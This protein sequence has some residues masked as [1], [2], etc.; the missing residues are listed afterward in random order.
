MVLATQ[1]PLTQ[2]ELLPQSVDSQFIPWLL[3]VWL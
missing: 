2:W 1:A 3:Q